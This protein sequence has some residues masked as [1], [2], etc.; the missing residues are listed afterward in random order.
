MINFNRVLL[1]KLAAFSILFLVPVSVF[2]ANPGIAAISFIADNSGTLIFG[3]KQMPSSN[4]S[5]GS[6]TLRHSLIDNFRPQ[7]NSLFCGDNSFRSVHA[8]IDELALT[9]S[10]VV[11]PDQST[12]SRTN[13]NEITPVQIALGIE[14]AVLDE[15]IAPAPE[16]ATSLAAALTVAAVAWSQ[17]H[18]VRRFFPP[19]A[20][21]PF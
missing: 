6:V 1:V 10:A 8:E 19:L 15:E 3:A 4:D 20:F 18:R 5:D 21:Y 16:P 2:A 7:P 11:V 14:T 17:R 12:P 13:G 9:N